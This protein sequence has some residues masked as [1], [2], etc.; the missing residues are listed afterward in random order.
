MLRVE[1][2]NGAEN[3]DDIIE[4]PFKDHRNF[5]DHGYFQ[6]F[7]FGT[8]HAYVPGM[9]NAKCCSCALALK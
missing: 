8:L 1:V 5:Y 9:A 6:V 4:Y 3:S 2:K 7:N